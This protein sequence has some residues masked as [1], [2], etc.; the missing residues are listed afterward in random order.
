MISSVNYTG[1]RCKKIKV[2]SSSVSKRFFL[3]S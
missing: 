2:W 1:G 3:F